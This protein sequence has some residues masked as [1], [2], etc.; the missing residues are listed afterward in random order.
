[1]REIGI[2]LTDMRILV[3]ERI[4]EPADIRR[5]QPLFARSF[6]ELYPSPVTRLFLADNLSRL[7]RGVI[8]DYEGVEAGWQLHD[9]FQ[10]GTD[11]IGF[12]VRRHN[13]Q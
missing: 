5:T 2:H 6:D 4:L 10:Q 13:Y 7:V 8:I 12:L 9:F 3:D 11:I 1:M